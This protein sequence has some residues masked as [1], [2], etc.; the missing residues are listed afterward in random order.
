MNQWNGLVKREWIPMRGSL[1]LGVLLS[2]VVLSLFPSLIN[3][4]MGGELENFEITLVLCFIW[5]GA[6]VFA[7]LAAFII[8]LQRDMKRPDIWLHSTASIFKLMGS[9]AFLAM[10]IGVVSLLI[11]TLVLAV[12]FTISGSREMAFGELFLFG[13]I[14]IVLIFVASLSFLSIGFFFFTIDRLVKRYLKGFSILF[15]LILFIFSLKLYGLFI[16]SAFYKKVIQ[17]GP[18]NIVDI[19][20]PNIA[21]N[22]DYFVLADTTFYTG[23]V[24]F[25][26]FTIVVLFMA[27]SV[28]FEKKVR[29]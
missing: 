16:L 15:T 29:L 17:S 9:K 18:V 28:L 4:L 6:S 5:A 27:A 1:I 14:F 12:R 25:E 8:S 22:F 13:S 11:P 7:P 26:I 21:V 3:R 10:V 24:L 23:E 19:V 2:L 20:N